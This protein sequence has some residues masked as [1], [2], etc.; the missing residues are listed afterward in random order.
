M[1]KAAALES[2]FNGLTLIVVAAATFMTAGFLG[3]S[4][5]G[6]Y[7][8]I[9]AI[10]LM[11]I[12]LATLRIETRIATCQSD[13][14]LSR[15]LSATATCSLLFV[16]AG[17]IVTPIFGIYFPWEIVLAVIILAAS[18]SIVET[19]MS[20]YSYEGELRLVVKYR[21]IKQI[22]PSVMVLM[23]SYAFNDFRLAIAALVVSFLVCVT[24]LL[25]PMRHRLVLSVGVLRNTIREYSNGLRASF[26]LGTMN[27]VWSNGLLPM[28]SAMGLSATAGQFAIV[29]RLMNTPLG[30]IGVSVQSVLLNSGNRLHEDARSI[31]GKVM[32]LFCI[33]VTIAGILYWSIYNQ[34]IFPF[35]DQWKLSKLLFYSAGFFFACSFA[36]GTMS[37][38]GVRLKDEWFLAGWQLVFLSLWT[39]ILII[40]RSSEAFV[41]MLIL[42]GMGYWILLS[43]WVRLS[44]IKHV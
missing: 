41:F 35:P 19:L 26:L 29:Q 30:V 23:S 28:M 24:I 13:E 27:A 33:A 40:F 16:M 37:I 4:D 1:Y 11:L 14:Q 12:P 43:R 17:L 9:Q 32:L 25:L 15:L 31:L 2:F 5:F 39:V 3:P 42:G 6:Q 18:A 44:K 36:V 21:A 34:T 20:S 7:A 8:A 10:A 22:L 38:L